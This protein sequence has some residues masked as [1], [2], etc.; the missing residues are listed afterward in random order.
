MEPLWPLFLGGDDRGLSNR[1]AVALAPDVE[2]DARTNSNCRIWSKAIL[3]L[4]NILSWVEDKADRK[5]SRRKEI[6]GQALLASLQLSDG[7]ALG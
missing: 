1:E 7:I 3:G 6:R 4:L 5:P 2:Y